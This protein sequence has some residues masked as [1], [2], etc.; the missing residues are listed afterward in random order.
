M[1]TIPETKTRN[2]TVVELDPITLTS[3]TIASSS[4]NNFANAG[5]TITVTLETDG[6]N[7]E[8]TADGLLSTITFDRKLNT[9]AILKMIGSMHART[10]V[11]MLDYNIS[12][13][14]SIPPTM[15]SAKNN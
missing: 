3:L 6:T 8:T 7:L 14:D 1:R 10:G 13:S 5:K 15:S 12:S 9:G 2:V 11:A 4:G